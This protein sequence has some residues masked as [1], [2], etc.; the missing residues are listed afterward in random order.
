MNHPT[1]LCQMFLKYRSDKCPEV[2]HSYSPVYFEYLQHRKEDF[3]NILEIG[4]GTESLM[5]PICGENYQVGAS[6]K[7]WRD[8]FI[9]ASIFGVDIDRSVLFEEERIKCFFTDQSNKQQLLNTI[10]DIRHFKN[11]PEL[12]FDLIIDDG[13]HDVNHMILSFST[14]KDYV[15]SGGLYII[16]DIKKIDLSLFQSLS[17]PKWKIIKVHEGNNYWDAFII[18]Q[19]N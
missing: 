1:E 16:E 7:A 14:L 13:S 15:T 10:A 5:R 4:I 8:F 2:S 18:Y 9:H 3:K 12:L 17:F 19:N 6:L 11:D